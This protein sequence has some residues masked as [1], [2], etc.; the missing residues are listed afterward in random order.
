MCRPGDARA[1]SVK[2]FKDRV[3]RGG[4]DEWSGFLIVGPYELLDSGDQLLL[5]RR[6]LR[7]DAGIAATS[8]HLLRDDPIPAFHL[9]Q[10]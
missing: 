4:P 5:L 10:P 6:S 2:L 3:R 7:L 1:K 8:N 9:I